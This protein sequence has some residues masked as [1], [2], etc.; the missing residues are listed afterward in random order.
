MSSLKMDPEWGPVWQVFSSL[1][2]PVPQTLEWQLSTAALPVRTDIEETKHTIKSLD[3]NNVDVYRF[4][5]PAAAS[6]PETTQR[7]LLYAFGGGMVAGS[8]KLWEKSLQELAHRTDTQVFAVDYRLAP[9]N[10]APAAVEDFYSAAK[11]LQENAAQFNVD[12]KRIVLYGK[13]AGAGIAAGTA[14]MA[15][16]K[17]GLP[18]KLAAVAMTYPMLDDRTFLP[19]DHLLHN[20]LIWTQEWSDLAWPALLGKKREERTDE[21]VSIYA[22]PARAKDLSGLPDAYIDVGGLDLFRDESMQF[23]SRL[24]SAGVYVE[25]HLYPGVAH[26]FDS[27][28][29]MKV[30]KEARASQKRFFK[31]Y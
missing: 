23:A 11:W 18:H 21:N 13:S 31:S 8:V 22:A 14:L 1:P 26:G 27:V 16:D 3:G 4:V 28:E 20:Y 25:F 17:G 12:P 2:K 24:Q 19:A 9:E 5:P 29:D 10:P 15:R 6:S 30:A 7:A